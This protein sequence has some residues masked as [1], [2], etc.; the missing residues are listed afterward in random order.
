MTTDKQMTSTSSQLRNKAVS[1][2][3]IIASGGVFA[4]T[5][6]WRDVAREDNN[7]RTLRIESLKVAMQV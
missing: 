1:L 3:S 5:A 7:I 4:A 6:Q 2:I